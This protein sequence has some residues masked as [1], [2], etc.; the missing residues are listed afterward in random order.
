[1]KKWAEHAIRACNVKLELHIQ[2]ALRCVLA[3]NISWSGC[4]E[5]S[6][7]DE[8]PPLHQTLSMITCTL[9]LFYTR[10]RGWFIPRQTITQGCHNNLK[11]IFEGLYRRRQTEHARHEENLQLWSTITVGWF[12]VSGCFTILYECSDFTSSVISRTC[13]FLLAISGGRCKCLLCV[14][15]YAHT[16]P[17]HLHCLV[18]KPYD[19]LLDSS[20][21]DPS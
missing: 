14:C 7:A 9:S 2:Q 8:L 19:W 13:L 12:D 20:D 18:L 6:C 16:F 4:C 17:I 15:L 5:S 10:Q 11:D 21:E 3:A 1:M